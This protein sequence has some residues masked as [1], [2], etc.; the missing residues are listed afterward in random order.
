M[1]E[2]NITTT[3]IIIR[4][5]YRQQSSSWGESRI[6]TTGFGFRLEDNELPIIERQDT[7]LEEDDPDY[8]NDNILNF[9]K[10]PIYDPR[11]TTWHSCREYTTYTNEDSFDIA[12][13]RVPKF[14]YFWGSKIN[15]KFWSP[16]HDYIQGVKPSIEIQK[17]TRSIPTG[18]MFSMANEDEQ[19]AIQRQFSK[20]L[21]MPK[22]EQDKYIKNMYMIPHQE[23]VKEF[24]NKPVME[25][26]E[27]IQR[28]KRQDETPEKMFDTPYDSNAMEEFFTQTAPRL[29][30]EINTNK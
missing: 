10:K 5:S 21:K 19:R 29:F 11:P 27:I 6:E 22:E 15:N 2:S 17:Q 8:K 3:T 24:L 4:M 18:L 9:D 25:Q 1:V 20:I 28:I 16:G 13:G 23:M 12:L 7:L 26:Y 30:E 14:A